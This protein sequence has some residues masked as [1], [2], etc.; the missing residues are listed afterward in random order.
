[1]SDFDR[2]LAARIVAAAHLTGEFKLRSGQTS[3]HY[4][5]KY[6]FEADPELLWPIARA[7]A[8]LVP[9]GTEVLAGLELGGVPLAVAL[10][11]ET[12]L[13]TAFVRKERKEYGT[14][15]I[16]EG[17]ELRGRAVCVIEDVITTGGQVV[18][19]VGDLR[20]EGARVDSV[21]CVIYRGEGVC[22]PLHAAGLQL[23]HLYTMAQL[24]G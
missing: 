23:I 6:R 15:R 13:P 18:T 21:C 8:P 11:R 4:F 24:L 7:M 5:D 19:S 14:C 16:A 2:E 3:N 10:S 22:E 9:S 12:G 1:M 20:A 17:A